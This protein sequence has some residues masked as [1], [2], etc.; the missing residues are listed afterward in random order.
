VKKGEGQVGFRKAAGYTAKETLELEER[1]RALAL[2]K[3]VSEVA[4][5][6]GWHRSRVQ[7]WRKRL[8]IQ[9]RKGTGGR[10]KKPAPRGLHPAGRPPGV[11]YDA[12]PP[13]EYCR[14]C[15]APVSNWDEHFAR[16]GHRRPL[17]A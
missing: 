13:V 11:A 6:L 15:G 3:T 5:E 12:V 17:T 8:L 14:D 1:I 9:F 4:A 2:S 10:K 7:D 16:M